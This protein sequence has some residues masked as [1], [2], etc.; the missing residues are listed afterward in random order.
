MSSKFDQQGQRFFAFCGFVFAVT[1]GVGL[2]GFL[3][4]PPSFNLSAQETAHYYAVHQ[5]GFQ[6]GITLITIGMAFLL[7]WTVQYGLMLWRLKGGSTAVA[8]VTIASLLASPILLSFDLAIFGIAAFRPTHTSPDVTRALSD[9]AWIGS[10]LIWPMLAAG[11][12]LGGVLI[13]KTQ[14]Q[15]GAFPAYLGWYSLLAAAVELFQIPIIFVKSGPFAADGLF[16]WYGTIVTWGIWAIGLSAAMWRV[17]GQ[18]VPQPE[19][20]TVDRQPTVGL[21]AST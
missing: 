21:R 4:Q 9:I 15:P 18:T 5:T 1:V 2:E 3:P 14:R 20:S 19:R 11:M 10:E 7:A 8:A 13:L 17:L 12:A 16:P 6:I